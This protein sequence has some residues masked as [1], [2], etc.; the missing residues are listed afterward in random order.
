MSTSN[1]SDYLK[2]N[3][4]MQKEVFEK[5]VSKL[6]VNTGFRC[7]DVGCG[8]GNLTKL[9]V[10]LVGKDGYVLG[11][12]PD[13]GR[14][15]LAKEAFSQVPNL[16]F[17]CINGGNMETDLQHFDIVCSNF[18]L[19]WMKN[20]EKWKTIQNV[21]TLLKPGGTFGFCCLLQ[22][23]KGAKH[24]YN[25]VE[26]K[27]KVAHI[28]NAEYSSLNEYKEKVS[29]YMFEI[30][31]IQTIEHITAFQT[32]DQLL[33]WMNASANCNIDIFE[34]YEKHKTDIKFE[35]NQNGEYLKRF[36]LIEVLVKK[37]NNHKNDVGAL[38]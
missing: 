21:F 15:N 16:D 4:L 33:S 23:P 9:L 27:E 25:F 8:P 12:D 30:V 26:D 7:L 3:D 17:I 36:K 13:E 20:E 35:Q 5:L 11:I 38:A 34:L 1:A 24:I 22:L 37:P 32:L 31:E 28:M 19:H 14:I 6:G 2:H 10:D 18:V 29:Q